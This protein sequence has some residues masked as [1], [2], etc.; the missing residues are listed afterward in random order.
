MASNLPA[1]LKPTRNLINREPV[2]EK[3]RKYAP[4]CKEKKFQ[5]DQ[6]TLSMSTR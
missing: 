3:F 5:K 2:E 1:I 6:T 4:E